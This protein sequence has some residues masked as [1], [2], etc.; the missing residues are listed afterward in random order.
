MFAKNFTKQIVCV[1]LIAI[2]IEDSDMNI[3]KSYVFKM[4]PT[5]RQYPLI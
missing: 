4:Y 1:I 5:K 2:N 3:L